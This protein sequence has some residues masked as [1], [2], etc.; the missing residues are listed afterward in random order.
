MSFLSFRKNRSAAPFHLWLMVTALLFVLSNWHCN[1]TK[2][3][4]S[5]TS[6]NSHQLGDILQVSNKD[7]TSIDAEQL[8]LKLDRVVESR[9]PK[10]TNCIRAG[11][12]KATL[13][14]I[15]ED[16]AYHIELEAKGHCEKTDGS[17]GNT[18]SENGYKFTL[19]WLAPYPGVD[20]KNLIKQ[21]DYVAHV[22]VEK[23]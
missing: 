18:V 4:G 7:N 6:A 5:S 19:M 14:I 17:C 10:Y 23:Q 15:K 3:N 2:K 1:T 9:C 11:E 21:E 22:K 16:Y 13:R 20:G 8:K 12:A